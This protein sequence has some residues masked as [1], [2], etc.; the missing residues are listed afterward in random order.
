MRILL[1]VPH[2]KCKPGF[3]PTYNHL[4]DFAAPQWATILKRAFEEENIEVDVIW[5]DIPRDKLDLNRIQGND[6]MFHKK[7]RTFLS[8]HSDIFL[9]DCHSYPI[10]HALDTYPYALLCNAITDNTIKKSAQFRTIMKDVIRNTKN[11]LQK[12]G[13]TINTDSVNHILNVADEFNTPAV[14]IE[15]SPKTTY[16]DMKK[17]AKN[18]VEKIMNL[19]TSNITID[20]SNDLYIPST[21]LIGWNVAPLYLIYI[22]LIILICVVI[23]I[24]IELIIIYIKKYKNSIVHINTRHQVYSKG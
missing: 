9:I 23:T 14:L 6:T 8:T 11:S 24:F 7:I 19:D 3:D 15:M 17:L 21:S 18:I 1:T 5:G 4:C 22:I 10:G 13:I 16:D 2:A 20:K 12:S